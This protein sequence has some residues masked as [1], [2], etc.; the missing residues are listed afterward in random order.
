MKASNSTRPS[1][2]ALSGLACATLPPA[3]SSAAMVSRSQAFCAGLRKRAVSGPSARTNQ[4][5]TP[6]STAGTP[7]ARN[8]HCQPRR[9]NVL[10]RSSKLP[11]IG[12]PTALATTEA[13]MNHPTIR[14]RCPNGTHTVSRYSTPGKNP[15]SQAPSRNRST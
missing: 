15:A 13:I 6:I 11:Q 2:R 10:S 4:V 1:V 7:V 12:A 9:P 14:A 3:R 8:T 5:T